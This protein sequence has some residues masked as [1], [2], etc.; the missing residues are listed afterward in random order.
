MEGD[1][2]NSD[3]QDVSLMSEEVDRSKGPQ[4]DDFGISIEKNAILHGSE[5][6]KVST[7]PSGKL[8]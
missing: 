5:I 7:V 6:F 1:P 2:Y 4:M 3:P 8:T